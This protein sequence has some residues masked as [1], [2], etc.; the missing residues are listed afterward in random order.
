LYAAELDERLL[1][2][3]IPMSTRFVSTRFGR[4][5]LCTLVIASLARA[6]PNWLRPRNADIGKPQSTTQK[7]PQN[8]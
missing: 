5:S 7:E 4:D 6:Q 2:P 1:V 3:R 8:R